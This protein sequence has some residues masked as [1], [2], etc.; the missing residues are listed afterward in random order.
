[1]TALIAIDPLAAAD[2]SRIRVVHAPGRVNLIGEHTDYNAGF[3]LP[4]AI[5]LGISIALLPTDDRRV[6]LTLEA[7]GETDR[8]DLDAIPPRSGRWIDYVAATAWAMAAADLPVR[9]FRGVLA[10]GPA[11][12][13][14]ALELGRARAGVGAGAGGRRGARD[15]PDDAG[16]DRPARRERVR[17]R[18][19]RADGPVRLGDGRGRRRAPARLPVARVPGRAAAARRGGARGDGFRVDAAARAFRVQRAPR[20]V[21]GSRRRDRPERARRR[22]APRRHAGDARRRLREPRS[23]RCC[24]APATS[25][26]RT[27]GSSRPSPRSTPATSRRPAGS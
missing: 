14:R 21:R 15:R 25:S 24:G 22:D 23:G 16:P 27:H 11:A 5:D 19:L 26:T 10:L 8:I 20:P 2:P 17:R 18:R 7:T 9:G 4:L 12:G 13:R 1:M 3:V 6:T